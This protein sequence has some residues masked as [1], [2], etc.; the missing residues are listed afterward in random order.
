MRAT[1][2]PAP[3]QDVGD[4]GHLPPMILQQ[5]VRRALRGE[6]RRSL[7]RVVIGEHAEGQLLGPHAVAL[8]RVKRFVSVLPHRAVVAQLRLGPRYK[9]AI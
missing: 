7:R 4:V 6:D 9:H 5:E 3:G 2:D 8:L 1:N